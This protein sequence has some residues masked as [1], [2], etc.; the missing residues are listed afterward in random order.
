MKYE[1]CIIGIDVGK[2]E[3]DYAVV[4]DGKVLKAGTVSNSSTGVKKIV[5]LCKKYGADV[6]MEP[7]GAYEFLFR[8]ALLLAGIRCLR[9]D[10]YKVRRYSQARYNGT[11][12]D[13]LDARVIAEF[14]CDNDCIPY[15]MPDPTQSRLRAYWVMCRKYRDL[16][17]PFRQDWQWVPAPEGEKRM[18]KDRK[19]MEKNYDYFYGLCL[20]TIRSDPAMSS[21]YDRFVLVKGIGPKT[22]VTVLAFLPEIGRLT[23]AQLASLVGVAPIER[24]SGKC[25]NVRHIGRGRA[26][27]RDVIYMAAM[28]AVMHNRILRAYYKKKRGEGHPAKWC[29]VPV[30]RK[31]LRLMSRIARDPNFVPSDDKVSFSRRKSAGKAAGAKGTTVPDKADDTKTRT[32]ETDWVTAAPGMGENQPMP[33]ADKTPEISVRDLDPSPI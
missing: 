9:V 21:L 13:R 29:I 27:V 11:K 19:A 28:A 3:N 5:S 33:E 25:L 26:M 10:A 24:S 6:A 4:A 8:D 31:L 1:K 15:E 18:R 22:A 2:E 23:N 12:N 32:P 20:E 17:L 16:L 30:M 14:A 7:T